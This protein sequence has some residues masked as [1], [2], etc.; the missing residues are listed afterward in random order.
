MPAKVQIWVIRKMGVCSSIDGRSNG[1]LCE[2]SFLWIVGFRI[3]RHPY[4]CPMWSTY[5]LYKNRFL[6]WENS[7]IWRFL[8]RGYTQII[9]FGDPPFMETSIWSQQ[10]CQRHDIHATTSGDSAR[11]MSTLYPFITKCRDAQS[12]KRRSLIDH[13]LAVSLSNPDLWTWSSPYL[14]VDIQRAQRANVM[15]IHVTIFHKLSSKLMICHH[16]SQHSAVTSKKIE[17][18]SNYK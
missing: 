17:K 1:K 10:E 7:E 5:T 8:K 14:V 13:L 12:P 18:G 3:S 15:R 4:I 2:W 6:V 11:E 9:H 16:F